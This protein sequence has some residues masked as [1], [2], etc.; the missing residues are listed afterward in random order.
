MARLTLTVVAILC[1]IASTYGYKGFQNLI[2]NG[3]MVPNPCGGGIWG[4]VGHQAPAGAGPKNPFGL[5]FLNADKNWTKALC[6]ADSDGDGMS[7]GEELG[8][9]DCIWMT[10]NTPNMTTGITHPGVCTPVNSAA[11]C[12]KQ[13]WLSCGV[14]CNT[15]KTP[16]TQAAATTPTN[17]APQ[18]FAYHSLFFVIS[19]LVCALR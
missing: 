15:T 10:G 7:N 13:S 19:L 11:C 8:D 1:T 6:Q 5:A 14:A 12:G 16:A 3:N 18:T 2:P 17:G 4:G 9:P